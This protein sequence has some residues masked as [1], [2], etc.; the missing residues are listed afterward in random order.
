MGVSQGG[1]AR[2]VLAFRWH[3]RVVMLVVA[4]AGGLLWQA[5]DAHATTDIHCNSNNWPGLYQDCPTQPAGNRHTYKSGR[6]SSGALGY[7]LYHD[8]YVAYT[9]SNGALKYS[10]HGPAGSIL[11]SSFPNNTELL[12]GYA[13]QAYAAAL[14]GEGSY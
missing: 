8:W 2:I 11:Y 10:D 9:S 14:Y 1:V 4:L 7:N 6:A 5:S 13:S 3:C 12:R